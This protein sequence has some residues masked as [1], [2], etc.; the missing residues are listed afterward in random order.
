MKDDISDVFAITFEA[1]KAYKQEVI[2]F[3]DSYFEAGALNYLENNEEQY[4]A[5]APDFDENHFLFSAREK[6]ILLPKYQIELFKNKDWLKECAVRF[7]PFEVG[8][9]CVYDATD[10]KQPL[11][12]KTALGIYAVTAFGSTHPTTHLCL[13]AIST[14]FCQGFEP[15]NILDIGTGSGI[16]AIAG[17]KKWQAVKPHILGVDIDE[18][19]VNVAGQNVFDNNVSDLIDVA[20]SDGLKAKIVQ[21][22]APF[23]LV[24]ANILAR[25][26]IEMAQSMSKNMLQRGYAILSGFKKDQ[27]DW[28]LSAYLKADFKLI[29]L[30]QNQDWCAAVLQKKENILDIQSRL[31]DDEAML[32]TREN[33]FLGEDIKDAENKILELSGFSGSAG[34][35]LIGKLFAYLFVDGRY[36]I[37]A[38][39]EAKKGIVVI[40]SS[41]FIKDA[42]NIF[43]SSGLKKMLVNPW[44]VSFKVADFIK[45]QNIF[46]KADKNVPMSSFLQGE[47][48]F[49]HPL[50][51]AGQTR[52]NKCLMVAAALPSNADALLITSPQELSWLSNMRAKDLPYSPVMRAFGLLKKDGRLKIYPFEQIKK[53]ISDIKKCVLVMTDIAKMPFAFALECGNIENITQNHLALLK[54]KKNDT[55]LKGFIRAHIKDGVALVKFLFELEKNYEG[56][57]ELDIVQKLHDLR[58]RQKDY[59]SESFATIAAVNANAAIVHY[60]PTMKTNKKVG[61][62]ALLL[63]DSGAEYFDGT[64]DVTRTIAFGRIKDDVK[65]A[66]TEVLKAHIALASYV[67]DEKTPAFELDKVCRNVLLSMGKDYAH[68]TGHSVGHFSNVHEPP[69]AINKI[70]QTPVLAHYVTSIEP[71]YYL[72]HRFGIRIENL[73][74][75]EYVKGAK[76]LC[77]KPLTLCPIEPNLIKS[78]ML[79]ETEK[80]WL[81]DY[82]QLVFETLSKH[83]NRAQKAWLAKKCQKI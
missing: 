30:Y 51:F 71:G 31:N 81:N 45:A 58:A 28:V 62:N 69:F 12:T 42:V 34:L 74:Y 82:H 79:T 32:I 75:T 73:Y 1:Q 25:P 78:E 60:E 3:F 17:A 65:T 5:Y 68:G 39:M 4:V 15:K 67:F 6:N 41:D 77:F 43:K 23:D 66:F 63:I 48:M 47:H 56:L 36:S 53:L 83:L 9:F 19:S 44:S 55:E 59:F 61:K 35:M 14:L 49:K 52:Q 20:L 38:R 8:D 64:T 57:S 2:D 27:I 13:E 33:M 7:A 50:R 40:D 24:F 46:I 11:T 26:L 37:Q 54:L 80:T 10:D 21:K 70:N 18:T 16:L 76:K 72:K 29:R 22:N